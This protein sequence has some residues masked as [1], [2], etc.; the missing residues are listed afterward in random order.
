VQSRG[1]LKKLGKSLFTLELAMAVLCALVALKASL[2]ANHK[3]NTTL[4][5]DSGHYMGTAQLLHQAL[6][7]QFHLGIAGSAPLNTV[8][9]DW[10]KLNSYLLLDGPLVPVFGTLLFI[11]MGQTP[12]LD[13]L[14]TFILF[15]SSFQA[16]AAALVASLTYKLTQRPILSLITAM[17]WALYP[18]AILGCDSFLGEVPAAALLLLFIRLMVALVAEES[19]SGFKPLSLALFAGF[20]GALVF[21]SKPA[22]I[23]CLGSTTLL[24]LFYRRKVG[25][26]SQFLML[27]GLLAGAAIMLT[28]WLIYTHES[29]GE[30][31]IAARRQPTFNASKGSDIT[32]DGWG[33]LPYSLTQKRFPEQGGA[34]NCLRTLWTEAPLASINLAL[35]KPERLWMTPWNDFHHYCLGLS[36]A[37]QIVAHQLLILL[38]AIGLTISPLL[39]LDRPSKEAHL[40]LCT[41]PLVI[42]GH[43]AYIPFETLARYGF[44]A[45]PMFFLLA[46]ATWSYAQSKHRLPQL[47]LATVIGAL[48]IFAANFD[49]LPLLS[50]VPS[51]PIMLAT[52]AVVQISIVTLYLRAT[53][54][55]APVYISGSKPG[56]APGYAAMACSRGIAITLGLVIAAISLAHAAY[57]REPREWTCRLKPGEKI[58]RS[59][60]IDQFQGKDS[61]LMLDGDAG[62][63]SATIRL[64]SQ[65][66]AGPALNPM[67]LIKLW[68][69]LERV[70]GM[71]ACIHGHRIEQIRQ[72]R[73]FKIPAGLVKPGE[74]NEIELTANQPLTIYGAYDNPWGGAS[75]CHSFNAISTGRLLNEITGREGRVIT[76]DVHPRTARCWR[77]TGPD[78]KY[79]S[80]DLAAAFGRQSGS[81]KIY[82]LEN[83]PPAGDEN[84]RLSVY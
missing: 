62:V 53:L 60:H 56:A 34:L 2:G 18:A 10:S 39:Y 74:D 29:T 69:D 1:I 47:A 19:R 36:P 64:N 79:C 6:A 82:I 44:S 81:Y 21:S 45:M 61:L 7:A 50:F 41:A 76:T 59:V 40:I 20:C 57:E 66:I 27:S 28:P 49:W 33:M 72:W 12:T 80:D 75:Y 31:L 48:A 32:S 8:F 37:A 63:E 51:L 65:T 58:N 3:Y 25:L 35:R 30:Y 83:T 24:T 73:V 68:C 52:L 77:Q 5:F 70:Q 15:E 4:L 38:A 84:C 11:L 54:H 42:L 67:H 17:A 23:L 22:L 71:F 13:N 46:A 26:K 78:G 43:M 55:I 9:Q 14:N 16:L